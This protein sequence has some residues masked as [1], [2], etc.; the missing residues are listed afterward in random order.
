MKD[1]IMEILRNKLVVGILL[2][3]VGI[4]MICVPEAY[5]S[6]LVRIA[7]ILLLIAAIVRIISYIR[8]ERT[9]S[10]VLLLIA[11]IIFAGFGISFLANPAWVVNFIY[12]WFGLLVILDGI[13]G[14]YNAFAVLKKNGLKWI[15]AAVSSLIVLVFGVIVVM[16]PFATAAWL[17]RFIGISL[18]LGGISDICSFFFGPRSQA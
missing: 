18:A 13:M 9:A 6:A 4:G 10:D 1:K 5:I 16:N 11:G 7:G 15:P 3:I 17:Y 2:L 12:I 14:I 8:S